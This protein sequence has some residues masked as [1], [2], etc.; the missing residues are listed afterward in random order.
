MDH[1]IQLSRIASISAPGSSWKWMPA[2]SVFMRFLHIISAITLLGGV[3][4]WRFGAVPATAALARETQTKVGDA[5]A[6]AWRPFVLFA[7]I[8]L[9]VSGGCNFAAAILAARP[10]NERRERQLTGVAISGIIIVILSAVLRWL[11]TP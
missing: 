10:N 8:G 4:A 2:L 1:Y 5:I 11:T 6:S 3:F 7:V 9:L